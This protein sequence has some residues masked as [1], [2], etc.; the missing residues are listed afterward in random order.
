MDPWRSCIHAVPPASGLF[1]CHSLPRKDLGLEQMLSM[2]AM[3]PGF[4]IASSIDWGQHP[5]GIF[6]RDTRRTSK[7]WPHELPVHREISHTWACG[8]QLHLQGSGTQGL[9]AQRA[10]VTAGRPHTPNTVPSLPSA[11]RCS[12]YTYNLY[13]SFIK[14][15]YFMDLVLHILSFF[16]LG[17]YLPIKAL[18]HESHEP[19]CNLHISVHSEYVPGTN[20][21]GFGKEFEKYI[22]SWV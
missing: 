15:S 14:Y 16:S 22:S 9:E 20:T 10:V 7:P 18:L 4:S 6:H 19:V 11:S 8:S 3:D 13:I 12:L 1:S 5:L 17:T 21:C 2:V